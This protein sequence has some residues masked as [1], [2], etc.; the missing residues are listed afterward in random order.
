MKILNFG[1]LNIDYVY[2]VDH[3]VRPG[4]TLSSTK[5]TVFNGG[6]GLNQTIALAR[7]GAEVYHA[8]GVGIN[9]GK[10]LIET[11]E[12][13]KV[14]T[15]FI[16]K[17]QQQSGHT[18]IQ[19]DKNGQNCI[20]LY[21]G[22][23][24]KNTTEFIDEVLSHFS[25]DDYI[26]LQNEINM[27]D[28]IMKKAKEIGLKIFLNPSPMNDNISKLPLEYVDYFI[29]N[30]VEASDICCCN[31]HDSL[32]T[33]LSE[34]MP[35]AKIVLTLGK[36]GV[37]YKDKETEL[38]HGIYKVNVVDTTAAGD[39]FTGYFIHSVAIGL[40]P[41]EALKRASRYFTYPGN[42]R[43]RSGTFDCKEYCRIPRRENFSTE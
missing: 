43:F 19:V 8:G 37:K 4:E 5:M 13:S 20:L 24:Q 14:N 3:F 42:R 7:A 17:Y 30:E 35:K 39:T 26:V 41:A 31:D 9:D 10:Q 18:I 1:S 25:S 36:H 11:L 38:S 29:L 2:D 23:N 33:K 16:N 21:G 12:R 22:T 34:K 15:K 27:V 6:K 28:Y 32:L 40:S